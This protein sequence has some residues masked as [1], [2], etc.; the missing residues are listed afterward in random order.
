MENGRKD[1]LPERVKGWKTGIK[2]SRLV[3][4]FF[5]IF[6]QEDESRVSVCIESREEK[7]TEGG[8]RRL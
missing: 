7:K 5:F 6:V 2:H 1:T 8:E 3:R 4:R